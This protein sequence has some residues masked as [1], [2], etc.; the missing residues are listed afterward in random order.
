MAC[1]A[2]A[3]LAINCVRIAHKEMHVGS[4]PTLEVYYYNLEAPWISFRGIWFL[5]IQWFIFLRH[6]LCTK[7]DDI[8][9]MRNPRIYSQVIYFSQTASHLHMKIHIQ[10]Y[11][12]RDGKAEKHSWSSC[13][14]FCHFA[15]KSHIKCN[16]LV[17][18]T[19]ANGLND[20]HCIPS[21]L[22][23]ICC[24][25]LCV[26]GDWRDCFLWVFFLC[27]CVCV[28]VCVGGGGGGGGLFDSWIYQKYKCSGEHNLTYETIF[29]LGAPFH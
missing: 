28:C 18:T 27:V 25:H 23:T 11:V 21:R 3:Q 17:F 16:L 5:P 8:L 14:P 20:A 19:V 4:S 26:S 10:L 29:L 6:T 12:C 15:C 2:F 13:L 22:E 1:H 7:W 24:M 9:T